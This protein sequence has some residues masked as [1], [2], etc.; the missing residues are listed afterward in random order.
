MPVD[1]TLYNR[2]GDLWWD[3]REVFSFLRTALN[4]GRFGYFRRVLL[5]ALGRDPRGL[6]ALD[7]GCGGGLLAEEFARLGCRVTGIDPSLPSLATARR[8]AARS[9]LDI[10]YF[11]GVGEALPFPDATFDLAYCCDVLEH[12]ADLD[13]V[14]AE[15]ARVLRPGGVYLFDTINRTPLS[16]L[17][18][19]KVF[20]DWPATSVAPPG[21]HD[22]GMFIRPAELR[23]TLRRHGLHP[24]ET[25]GLRPSGNPLALL[26]AVLRHRR[27]ELTHGEVGR[28]VHMRPSRDTSIMYM[29]YA[30]RAG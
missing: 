21:L 5:G 19:I 6:R 24:Q 23:A 30:I 26:D 17:V 1:N 22:W 13:R 25:V 12:V 14:V 7:I 11:A 29:G 18:V 20:Q 16:N 27:G 28:R 8:H 3:E 10:A 2:P 15:T 9:G 4:P